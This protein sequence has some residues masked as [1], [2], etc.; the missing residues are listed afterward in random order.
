MS[1][2]LGFSKYLISAALLYAAFHFNYF[3][4][5]FFYEESRIAI[6]LL[7]FLF[8][9]LNFLSLTFRWFFLA[10]AVL[11]VSFKKILAL[12]WVGS[13]FQYFLPGSLGGDF[14]KAGYLFK[15]ASNRNLSIFTIIFDRVFGLI[16]LVTISTVSCVLFYFKE[17]LFPQYSNIIFL[18]FLA[19]F[20]LTVLFCLV[21]DKVADKYKSLRS[22]ILVRNSYREKPRYV[23]F[24]LISNVLAHI[25]FFS[26]FFIGSTSL[27][28]K[29]IYYTLVIAPISLLFAAL[30]LSIGGLGLV[31]IGAALMSHDYPK[32]WSSRLVTIFTVLQTLQF[33][34]SL[35][36]CL[37]YIKIKK[38]FKVIDA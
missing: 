30:P 26:I 5:S 18:L 8:V 23:I 16:M 2:V 9:F 35:F 29:F 1:I 4:L 17:G 22:L 36:G 25:T 21:P 11:P 28:I 13:L 27:D 20:L 37:F 38:D 7:M 32:D 15:D 14:V 6:Y 19:S 33:L 31:Q 10:K 3:D 34:L 12:S 24:A